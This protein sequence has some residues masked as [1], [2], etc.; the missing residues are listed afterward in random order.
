MLISVKNNFVFLCAQKCASSAS[1]IMLQPFSDIDMSGIPEFKHTNYREYCRYI[2]P[3]LK[4]K[5]DRDDLETI[6]LVREPVSWLNSW[7]RFRARYSLRNPN[8]PAHQNS[9][10]GKSFEEFLEA[11][12]AEE[13]P[14]F[15][16]IQ[17]Q[18]NFLKDENNAV[19]VDTIFAYEDIDAFV[20]YMGGKVNKKLKITTE[21]T[22]PR[23]IYSSN[24]VELVGAV[25]RKVS[26]R[27]GIG[28]RAAPPVDYQLPD[29]LLQR[30]RARIP[31]DFQIH[32]ACREGAVRSVVG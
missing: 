8:H 23:K 20:D 9:T 32:E 13:R 3:Y 6:C 1:E 4:E 7:Y 18:F 15:A 14:P 19:G 2:K 22:S 10:Y 28:R 21:N 26:A 27:V 12:I 29:D 17:P 11:Y 25:K 30:L 31:Q 5:V 24:L 16:D